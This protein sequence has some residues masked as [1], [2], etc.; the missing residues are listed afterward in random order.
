MR[1]D[2]CPERFEDAAEQEAEQDEGKRE[3]KDCASDLLPP[4]LVDHVRM[5]TGVLHLCRQ[6]LHNFLDHRHRNSRR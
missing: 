1:E 3:A 2:Q 5:R 6:R 4:L